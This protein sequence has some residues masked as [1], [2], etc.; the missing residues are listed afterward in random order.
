MERS[1]SGEDAAAGERLE[2]RRRAL[3]KRFC[4]MG[5]TPGGAA[6]VLDAGGRIRQGTAALFRQLGDP[7]LQPETPPLLGFLHPKDRCA[8]SNGLA[9]IAGRGR[10]YG[11]WIVRLQAGPDA[12]RWCRLELS[13][14]LDDPEIAGVLVGIREIEEG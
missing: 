9:E 12:W 3:R 5:W 10:A 2:A 11:C 8:V 7:C 14:A 4:H 1:T 6:G 13:N